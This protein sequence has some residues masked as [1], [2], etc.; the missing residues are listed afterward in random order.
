MEAEAS[1]LSGRKT[2]TVFE[3]LEHLGE[4]CQ[5]FWEIAETAR[6]HIPPSACQRLAL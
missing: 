2:L 6:W 4:G 1:V 3:R 5:S